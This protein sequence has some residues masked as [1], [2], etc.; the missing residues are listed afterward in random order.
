MKNKLLRQLLSMSRYAFYGLIVQFFLFGM[1][2]ADKLAAQRQSIDDV[3]LHVRFEN[4]T[5]EEAFQSIEKKTGF[6]FAYSAVSLKGNYR[7]NL[8]STTSLGDILRYISRNT[9]LKFR[10]INETIHVSRKDPKAHNMIQVTEAVVEQSITVTGKVISGEDNEGLPG[11]NVV[12]KGTSHGT[13]TDLSGAFSID[14]PST[15]STLVFSSVGYMSE[16]VL[17]G[18]RSVIDMTLNPDVTAL[19]EIVVVGYGTQER[20]KVTGPSAG[21]PQTK[22][23]KHQQLLLTKPY[24]ARLP[25]YMS[26]IRDRPATTQSLG[27]AVSGQLGTTIRYMS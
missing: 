14:V 15:E 10:R 11:V 8:K 12:V 5:L 17:V 20:A 6:H 22:S 24:K 16:E 9:D 21:F 13:I 19:Q 27:F 1:I 25:V 2:K 26:P 3:H 18:K 7:L 23:L 4:K